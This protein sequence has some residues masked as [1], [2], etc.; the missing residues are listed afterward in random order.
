MLKEITPSS[1]SPLL[2]IS[3]LAGLVKQV[4]QSTQPNIYHVI[5]YVLLLLSSIHLI[6][7]P[8]SPLNFL[9]IFHILIVFLILIFL[10]F[11]RLSSLFLFYC[12]TLFGLTIILICSLIIGFVGILRLAHPCDG[13]LCI[14]QSMIS[15]H[16]RMYVFYSFGSNDLLNSQFHLISFVPASQHIYLAIQYTI[17][18]KLFL[19]SGIIILII[20]SIGIKYF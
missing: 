2:L 15:S 20:T 19:A 11:V 17:S 4:P 1:L 8:K 18:I 10:F 5:A 16:R 7:S 12:F 6:F 13:D 9:L 14:C 3:Q